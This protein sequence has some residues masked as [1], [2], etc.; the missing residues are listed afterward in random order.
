MLLLFIMKYII[1][2]VIYK[3]YNLNIQVFFFFLPYNHR[4]KFVSF[5]IAKITTRD[6]CLIFNI[7][8]Y[9][10]QFYHG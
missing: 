9:D 1:T 3:F 2:F 10:N 7:Q 4:V 6:K 5:D 8:Y